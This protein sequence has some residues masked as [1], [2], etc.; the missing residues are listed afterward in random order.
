M[1]GYAS[2]TGTRRNLDALRAAGWGLLVSASGCHRTEGFELYALDNGAYSAW[3]QG[4]D[5]NEG[6]FWRLLEAIGERAQW[7]VIPDIVCG[8]PR[9]LEYSMSWLAAIRASGHCGQMLLAVQDGMSAADV[10]PCIGNGV[11]L[12]V[13]GSTA[14][15]E[16]SLPIWG[17]LKRE[18]GCYLHVGR[19]NSLRRARLCHL[20]GADSFDGTSATRYAANIAKMQRAVSQST[21]PFGEVW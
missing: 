9:S 14:W 7:A 4:T 20:A 17:R 15:K 10:R 21:L 2:R 16:S 8:G 1:I 11:G 3:M 13:G 6:A 5:L 12:F 18:T 19:V